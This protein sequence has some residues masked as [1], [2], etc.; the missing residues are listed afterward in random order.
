[1]VKHKL[2]E[3][4]KCTSFMM[5]AAMSLQVAKWKFIHGGIFK[6]KGDLPKCVQHQT[7]EAK[8]EESLCGLTNYTSLDKFNRPHRYQWYI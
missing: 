6:T 5:K 1:M 4:K 3:F 7:T 8:A 2:A